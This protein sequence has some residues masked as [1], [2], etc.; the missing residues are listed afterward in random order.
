MYAVCTQLLQAEE[1]DVAA[2]PADEETALYSTYDEYPVMM[3][4]ISHTTCLE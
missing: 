3:P 2:S 4:V 1:S